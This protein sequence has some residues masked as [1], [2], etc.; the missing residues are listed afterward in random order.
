MAKRVPR[1][2]VQ[3]TKSDTPLPGGVSD[4]VSDRDEL[5]LKVLHTADWHLGRRFPS[6]PEEAQKKLSRARMEVIPR[7]F[8]VVVSGSRDAEQNYAIVCAKRGGQLFHW[9]S[10]TFQ[11]TRDHKGS[12]V[13]LAAHT[14]SVNGR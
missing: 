8:D 14:H 12:L 1:P 4:R 3:G 2:A 10:P 7:I 9:P 6:F 11:N 13:Y 5:V